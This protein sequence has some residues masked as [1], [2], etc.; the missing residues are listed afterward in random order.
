M[1]WTAPSVFIF[2]SINCFFFSFLLWLNGRSWT[3][4]SCWYA[5]PR[6]LW[7]QRYYSL[8]KVMY[9]L[10]SS[11]AST[12]SCKFVP[13]YICHLQL[14][15][16][17]SLSEGL[18]IVSVKV[19]KITENTKSALFVASARKNGYHVRNEQLKYPVTSLSV[20][21][22][23]PPALSPENPDRLKH[24]KTKW[25]FFQHDCFKQINELL[26]LI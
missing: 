4:R 2:P 26:F 25:H 5:K 11:M 10:S 8:D 15:L 7:N 21:F 22:H 16:K 20:T 19:V 23:F 1:H 12:A 24:V 6:Q 9:S 3:W 14:L 13:A 18:G 17:L